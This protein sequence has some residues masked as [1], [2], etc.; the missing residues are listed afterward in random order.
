[1]ADKFEHNAPTLI[2]PLENFFSVTPNDSTDLT[3]VTRAVLVGVSG[4]L[5]IIDRAGVTTIIPN[6][7]AGMFHPIRAVRI[8]D[9]NTTATSIVGAY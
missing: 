6:L 1:M 9:A 7:A 4:D 8:K 2:S 5:E 3:Y